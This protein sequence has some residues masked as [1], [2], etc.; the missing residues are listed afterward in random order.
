MYIVK[1]FTEQT[2]SLEAQETI[3]ELAK[4]VF[5]LSNPVK[6]PICS[7]LKSLSKLYR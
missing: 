5:T 7:R 3:Y 6:F 2:V 4:A 1:Y